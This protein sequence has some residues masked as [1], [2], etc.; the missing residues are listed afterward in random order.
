MLFSN[1]KV[2]CLPTVPYSQL[3]RIFPNTKEP[4]IVHYKSDAFDL[5]CVLL[6]QRFNLGGKHMLTPEHMAQ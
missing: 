3:I 4:D 6:N 2:A 5:Q 1:Q